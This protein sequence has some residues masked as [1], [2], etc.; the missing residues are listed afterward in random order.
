MSE[1]NKKPL[2]IIINGW[3]GNDNAGDEAILLSFLS[4]IKS[5]RQETTITV[6]SENSDRIDQLYGDLGV[7]GLYHWDFFGKRG[8]FNLVRGRLFKNIAAFF[9]ADLFVLGGG[10]ILRDNT[11]WRNLFRLLDEVWLAKLM[12]KPVAIYAIGVGPFKTKFGK[13]LIGKTVRMC[14][15]ITVREANSAAL[16]MDVGVPKDRIHIT[17]DPALLLPSRPLSHQDKGLNDFLNKEEKTINIYLTDQLFKNCSDEEGRYRVKAFAASLDEMYA[18][19]KIPYLFIP[20]QIA[21]NHDDRSVANLVT[22]Q[23]SQET[24]YYAVD[25]PLTAPEIKFLCAKAVLNITIRLHAMI[26]SIAENVP[27]VAINYEIKVGNFVRALDC[28]EF[29]VETDENFQK[30]LTEKVELVLANYDSTKNKIG[31]SYKNLRIKAQE[32]FDLLKRN[33]IE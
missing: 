1:N 31:E 18:R 11:S 16:L 2:S 27:V 26:F 12:G 24:G 4:N 6:L 33:F 17:A 25:L 7:T 19:F 13:W 32:T 8:F 14:D 9:R 23:L 10:S 21:D 20:M 15:L 3:Y 5:D 22:E 30:N 29:L 28:L